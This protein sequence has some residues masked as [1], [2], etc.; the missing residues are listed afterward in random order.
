M[1]TYQNLV[2]GDAVSGESHFT[3]AAG[4]FAKATEYQVDNALEA[5]ASA[6]V[7]YSQTSLK[8]RQEFL[9]AIN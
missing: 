6:F 7:E 4:E 3:T 1:K 9:A 2:A 5:A 8:K